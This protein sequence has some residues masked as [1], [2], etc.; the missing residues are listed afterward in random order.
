MDLPVVGLKSVGVATVY[1]VTFS[2]SSD[3]LYR[4]AFQGLCKELVL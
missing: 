3:S 4:H 1:S 2:K